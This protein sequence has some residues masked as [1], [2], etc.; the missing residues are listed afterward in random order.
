VRKNNAFFRLW[1][2]FHSRKNALFFRTEHGAAV[3]DILM[4]MTE[5]CRANDI[6]AWDYFVQVVRNVV[7]VRENPA[8][9]LPWTYAS[10]TG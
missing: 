5:T 9:W 10:A 7:A 8:G 3:G 1:K 4:S 6:R 2:A